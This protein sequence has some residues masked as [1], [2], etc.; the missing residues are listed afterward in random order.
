MKAPDWWD[1]LVDKIAVTHHALSR[2][3]EHNHA[4]TKTDILW[5][6]AGSIEA[7]HDTIMPLI[8][9]GPTHHADSIY[10]INRERA[11]VFI[12]CT[13]AERGPCIITYL[14]FSDTSRKFVEN[15]WPRGAL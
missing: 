15:F 12:L 13:S 8:G 9:R 2:Y 6:V 7:D 5:D 11:G 10:L 3:Q 4:A 14:R 1:Y